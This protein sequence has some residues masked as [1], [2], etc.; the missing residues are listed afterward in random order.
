MRLLAIDIGSSSVKAAVLTGGHVPR[1]VGRATFETKYDDIGDAPQAEVELA[2]I[3]RAV[4]D[5]VGQLGEAARRV[6]L[7]VPATMAPSWVAL[8]RR[9]R[10]LTRVVTHQDRRSIE[11]ARAIEARVGKGTHLRLAGNRPFPGGISS[12]TWAWHLAHAKSTMRRAALVGHLGTWLA[13]ALT[14]ARTI[15]TS[16]AGFTGLLDVR[17]LAWSEDLI[18]AA[19]VDARHLPE[20]V[21]ANAI[22]GKVTAAAARR[23]GVQAGVP[24]LTGCIDG[25]AAMLCAGARAGQ[26]VNVCGSTDVLALCV[27]APRPH[28]DLL[29]RPL[30]VGRRWLSVGTIAA[31]GTAM[32]WARQTLFSEMSPRRFFA[33][34]AKVPNVEQGPQPVRFDNALAGSR[35]S[36][37]VRRARIEGLTL[38]SSRD[39]ILRALLD[40]LAMQSARRLETFKQLRLAMRPDVF[41]TGGGSALAAMVLRRDWPRRFRFRVEEEATLRGL[42]TLAGGV[43]S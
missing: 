37:D 12:T 8:D 6:D 43:L 1:R 19:G 4:I 5:A 16:N 17:R 36:M 7:I 23:F 18:A 10:P 11:Q 26:L 41:V 24:M 29:T 21:E 15:D 32:G 30:G 25:S 35:T 38:S 28:A 40:D 2:A 13:H 20:V 39:E 3:E 31:A 33:H 14:G 9:G 22:V 42:Y 27:E 34:V